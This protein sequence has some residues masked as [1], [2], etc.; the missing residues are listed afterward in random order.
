[1]NEIETKRT[2]QKLLKQTA[3]SFIKPTSVKLQPNNK[4]NIMKKK[5]MKNGALQ[6]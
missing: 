4:R 3:G 6:Q 2:M 5:E 1:M